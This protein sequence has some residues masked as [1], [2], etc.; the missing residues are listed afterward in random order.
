VGLAVVSEEAGW[1]PADSFLLL[2]SYYSGAEEDDTTEPAVV[3]RA[4]ETIRT[5]VLCA[6]ALLGIGTGVGAAF[7]FVLP[8]S[9]IPALGSGLLL[10]MFLAVGGALAAIGIFTTL[11]VFGQWLTS[12][13]RT[14]PTE[15]RR[16]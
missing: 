16:R 12:E 10:S 14:P 1:H 7:R 11:S 8:T 13:R 6:A 2:A 9:T 3:W 4:Y 15:P 5:Q